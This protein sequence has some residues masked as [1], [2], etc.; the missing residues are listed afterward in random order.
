M[1]ISTGTPI[2]KKMKQIITI[3]LLFLGIS[4]YSQMLYDFP[5]GTTSGLSSF[6]N[7]NGV[8]GAGGKTNNT[9]K[10]NAFELVKPGESKIL[11]N[12]DGPG[13]IQRMWLTV[14]QNPSNAQ[15]PSFSNVL[16]WRN[17]TRSRCS[18]R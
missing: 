9:A 4:G 12:I 14:N 13:M 5:A 2:N 7:M 8:K 1:I 16:G 18:L 17:K 10:G 3:A 15:E 6:E 11:L